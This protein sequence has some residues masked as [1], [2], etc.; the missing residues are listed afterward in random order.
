MPIRTRLT[1]R[2]GIAHP[3]ISAPMGFVAGGKLAAAVTAAGGLGIIGGGYGDAQWLEREFA[4]AGNTRVGCGFI[5]W[6]LAKQPELLDLVLAH[7]PAAVMLSFGAPAPFAR[8]IKATGAQLICQVQSMAHARAALAAGAD[9]IVAQGG[10][11]GGHSEVRSTFTLVPEIADHLAKHAP[12]TVLVAAGGI[13]DGRGLAAA[14]MLGAEGV[15]IGSRFL[16]SPEALMPA[17]LQ[18]VILQADGDATIK[19]RALDVVRNYTWPPAITGRALRNRFVTTWHERDSELAVP[20]VQAR[21]FKRYA[22]ARD[23]GDADNTG[24]FVGEA[25]GLINEVRPAGEIVSRI[26]EEAE[27]ALTMNG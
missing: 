12:E 5:T 4:A 20:D 13:A 7:A 1:D 16:A 11:A 10:E 15:L 27:R 23:A 26:V 22:D 25:A 6:S 19:T 17:A 8:A 9:I 21:E 24:I 14:L 18:D 2:L 3:I